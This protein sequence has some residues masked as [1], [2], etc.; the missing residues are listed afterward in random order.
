MTMPEFNAEAS[1]YQ[2]SMR[3]RIATTYAN[4]GRSPVVQLARTCSN[5]FCDAF[6]FGPPGTCAKLCTDKIGGHEVAVLCKASECNPPC[7]QPLSCG[8]CTQT[9]TAYPDGISYSRSCQRG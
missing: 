2:T 7:D 9:C 8:P 3:Y 4:H 5:C 1:L 6:D